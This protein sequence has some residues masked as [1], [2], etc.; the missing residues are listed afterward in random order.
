[1]KIA[2]L[3]IDGAGKSTISKRIKTVFEKQGYE[4]KIVPFHKWIFADILRDKFKFGK[5]L[6]RDRKGRN[7]PYAPSKES[8]SSYLKPP[9]AFIDNVLFYLLNR[10]YKK[11]QIY[12]YDRFICAS[13]IKFKALNYHVDW[14]KALW[15]NITPD[16]TFVFNIGVEESVKR[17]ENRDDS[18]VWTKGQLSIEKKMYEQFA[19]THDLP[20]INTN[21]SIDV[22]LAE[23]I[24]T[25]KKL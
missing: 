10:P 11:N 14:F 9:V 4:V 15:W 23:I 19:K 20:L 25:I 18:Y 17:Q 22:V 13:Q 24:K 6:D 21:S 2:L 1:M 8:L 5:M 12:I 7:A 3:G 16:Y